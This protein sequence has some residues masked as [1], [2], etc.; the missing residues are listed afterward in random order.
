MC[1]LYTIRS[2]TLRYQVEDHSV[3]QILSLILIVQLD[4]TVEIYILLLLL[5]YTKLP[6][7]VNSVDVRAK[8]Q[9]NI[10]QV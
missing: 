5:S 2:H 9:S 4:S 8:L 3:M 7:N 10:I 1:G 6:I